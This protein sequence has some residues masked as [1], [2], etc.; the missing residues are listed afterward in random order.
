[1]SEP[2]PPASR[3]YHVTTSEAAAAIEHQGFRD[4][5]DPPRGVWL[6]YAPRGVWLADVP[7]DPDP[8]NLPPGRRYDACLAV[9]VPR[10]LLDEFE[11]VLP[12]WTSDCQLWCIPAAK[13]NAL[14]P[15]ERF[16]YA[17]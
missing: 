13:L 14:G 1:M 3:L 15:P 12:A 5:D 4:G 6:A 2:K 9:D 11:W 16:P 7:L 17:G 10:D 8:E